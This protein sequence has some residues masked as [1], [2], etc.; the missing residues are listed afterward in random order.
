MATLH[1]IGIGGTGHKLAA[2]CVHLAACGAFKGIIDGIRIACI[3]ADSANGNL[4][5]TQEL[6]SSYGKFYKALNQASG[7]NLVDIQM[8]PFVRLYEDSQTSL[9]ETFKMAGFPD[10]T[11]RLARFLYT[12]D[13][14]KTEFDMGFYGHTSIGTL[15]VK[16][17]LEND[18]GWDSFLKGI[19]GGDVVFLFGSIFGGTGA[20]VIPVVLGKLSEMKKINFRMRY[21]ALLLMPYFETFGDIRE[22]GRLQ[23]DS[24]SFH[25]KAKASLYYYANQHQYEN[26]DALYAIGEPREN[27]SYEAA[28]RGAH[29][30]KNKAHPVELFAASAVVDFIKNAGKTDSANKRKDHVIV[31][32]DRE[33]AK[34]KSGDYY[35]TWKMIRRIDDSL[36]QNI[37]RLMKTAVFYN[38][39]IYGQLKKR[40]DAA[41]DWELNYDTEL[42]HKKEN[43]DGSGDFLYDNIRGYTRRLVDWFYDLHKKNRSELDQNT[44]RPAWD[45]NPRVQILNGEYK[46]PFNN[47]PVSDNIIPH[48][49]EFVYHDEKPKKSDKIYIEFARTSPEQNDGRGFPALFNV[50]I[51]LIDKKPGLFDKK[52]KITQVD[53]P[54][55]PYLSMEGNV[56]HTG[57]TPP[58]AEHLWV[59]AQAGQLLEDI[60]DGLPYSVSEHFTRDS[61]SI[62]SPWSVFITNELILTGEETFETL[63]R[64]SYN[65]WCGLIALLALRELRAYDTDGLELK[66]LTLENNSFVNS[67]TTTSTFL[68][69]S[70]IFKDPAWSKFWAITLPNPEDGKAVTL[71]FLS[72]ETLVCPAYSIPDTILDKLH[73]MEPDIVNEKHE[74]QSPDCYFTGQSQSDKDAKYGLCIFLEELEKILTNC[75]NNGGSNE[76]IDKLKERKKNFIDDLRKNGREEENPGVIRLHSTQN[77]P[78]DVASI[79]DRYVERSGP[80]YLPFELTNTNPDKKAVLIGLNICGISSASPQAASIFVTKT[81]KYSQINAANIS[82]IATGKDGKPKIWDDYFVLY[83]NDLLNNTMVAVKKNDATPVFHSLFNSKM[84]LSDYE[85]VWPFSSVLLELYAPQALNDMVSVRDAEDDSFTV[86]LELPLAQ[87]K[88][89]I[90]KTYKRTLDHDETFTGKPLCYV[91]DRD[92][93]PLLAVWPYAEVLDSSKKNK[94]QRYSFFCVERDL[95]SSAGIKVLEIEPMF[96]PGDTAAGI[97]N[98]NELST[99]SPK[100][101]NPVKRG[102]YHRHSQTLPWAL[103]V[104]IKNGADPGEPA[105][106]VF[107]AKPDQHVLNPNLEWNIGLDFGT[108]STTAFY[109]TNSDTNPDF[110]RLLSEYVWKNDQTAIDEGKKVTSAVKIL[111]NSDT[112]DQTL[113]DTS[114]IDRQCFSQNSYITTFE[115]MGNSGKVEDKI[116][117]TGRIF[118]HNR[119][120]FGKINSDPTCIRRNSLK[121]NIKWDSG[122]RSYIDKYLNQLLT[123]IVFKAAENGVGKINWYFSYPSAFDWNS[124]EKYRNVLKKLVSNISNESGVAYNQNAVNG[125]TNL[126]T[127][128]IAAAKYLMSKPKYKNL[129]LF[130]CVDIGGGTSDISI[131]TRDSNLFQ[132]SVRFASR[133]M[134][135]APLAKLLRND[136]IM[137]AV[138]ADKGEDRIF[139]MLNYAGSDN[140]ANTEE[141]IRFFIETVLYEHYDEFKHRLAKPTGGDEKAYNKFKYSIFIAYTALCYYLGLIVGDLFCNKIIPE[142]IATMAL[143]LSGK[144]SKITD[145]IDHRLRETIRVRMQE[146]VADKKNKKEMELKIDFS[147]DN[148]VKTETAQ[149]LIIHFAQKDQ[150]E[151]TNEGSKPQFYMGSSVKLKKD[152]LKDISYEKNSF[153][154]TSNNELKHFI[155]APGKLETEFDTELQEFGAFLDFFNSIAKTTDGNME[156]ISLDWYSQHKSILYSRMKTSFENTLKEDERFEPPFISMVKA[157]LDYYSEEYLYAQ[158]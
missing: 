156:E 71:A 25:L 48:F 55:V 56:S 103:Q 100:V 78:A 135:V 153:I 117:E 44:G 93:V 13:E 119:E 65:T 133:D 85:V 126:T 125:P 58:D 38:K 112:A 32:A 23:P 96:K 30:Q 39:V 87:G 134:F 92:W 109:S 5:E 75:A 43:D 68:P 89:V 145:W 146:L 120:V 11:E 154:S 101:Y 148:S 51:R 131:W 66:Q 113:L 4:A 84:G 21:A 118:W 79:F 28:S 136:E 91:F 42:L 18:P 127:E 41:A 22:K 64:L 144:G 128:S 34:E 88:H 86:F 70:S 60:A 33:R 149:G 7:L 123:Q 72:H 122:D 40:N 59:A 82:G 106:F 9:N 81:H 17:I 76:I 142:D 15:I 53:Y 102:V 97:R 63:S 12:E 157:F 36:P 3:D 57:R 24:A 16:K 46:E 29:N 54:N 10:D 151:K 52:P 152:P 77:G 129:P 80:N 94:W 47:E 50:L 155:Q 19:T 111:C 74:F 37:Q 6:V 98:S 69:Y 83:D 137:K 73:I 121:T 110:V 140:N 8:F 90:T 150:T 35:Y 31:T 1:I 107:L 20:S 143:G 116:F 99:I 14:I 45:P 132:C 114:F 141:R 61:L 139:N 49:D 95:L 67:I 115:E 26:V 124:E 2:A 27:F 130:L 158:K 147:T 62:P 104:N 108:T 105:G 138:Y